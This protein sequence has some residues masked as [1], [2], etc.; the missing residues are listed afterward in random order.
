LT[1]WFFGINWVSKEGVVPVKCHFH[2][3]SKAKAVCSACGIGLCGQCLIENGGHVY[4][5]NC[6]S[7][8][9]TD[10]DHR[11]DHD[12]DAIESEDLIDLELMDMLDTDD[13]D[14]LF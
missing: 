14:G 7:A 13:D 8:R 5:D 11:S 3:R 10:D 12:D 2:P 1:T 4:C 6:Y 9:D